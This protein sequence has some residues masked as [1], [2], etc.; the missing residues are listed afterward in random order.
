MPWLLAEDAYQGDAQYAISVDGKPGPSGTVTAS[1]AQG[2]TQTVDLSQTLAPGNHDIA[3]SFLNDAYGGSSDT[4][5]NLYVKGVELN[6]APLPGASFTLYSNGTQHI[7]F[8]T[9]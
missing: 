6:G 7:S 4:D 2:Q 9:T 3:V 5:R 1:N 8:P